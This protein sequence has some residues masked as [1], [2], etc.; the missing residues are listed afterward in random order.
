MKKTVRL[1]VLFITLLLSY[2]VC[3][4]EP[5]NHNHITSEEGI[6]N[7]TSIVVLKNNIPFS[8]QIKQ[9]NSI[10]VIQYD[11]ELDCDVTIPENC[12][13]Q[14]EGGSIKDKGNHKLIG[15]N[16]VIKAGSEI[17]FNTNIALGGCWKVNRFDIRWFGVKSDD[18][19]IDCT[20]II[21][22]VKDCNIPIFFP[23]GTYY[24]S[25][26]YFENK[27][28]GSF[29]IIGEEPFG[30][31]AKVNFMPFDT[32]Q[33]YI[34]KIGGGHE[35]L[36]G[37]GRGYD[38]KIM[39]INFT[40]PQGYAPSILTNSYTNTKGEYLNGGLILDVV[41]IGEFAISGSGIHNMPFLTIGF[42]YE[43][44]FDYIICYGN[45]GKSS[46]PAIQIVN[47]QSQPYSALHVKKLMGEVVVG[48]MIK[49]VG[50]CA[51]SELV[52]DNF[53]FEGTIKWERESVF[54]ESRYSDTIEL[55]DYK[56][57]PIFDLDGCGF[58][59]VNAE[60][61]STNTKW[62]NSLDGNSKQCVRGLLNFNNTV[63]GVNILNLVSN[64]GSEW[65]YITG[66]ASNLYPVDVFIGNT[67]G[68]FQT[69]IRNINLIVEEK[70]IIDDGKAIP[71]KS[72]NL[73]ADGSLND[74][75]VPF[76]IKNRGTSGYI[77]QR[78]N[79]RKC[80]RTLYS[81]Y[82]FNEYGFDLDTNV[83]C[84][85]FEYL[86]DRMSNCDI[87]IEYFDKTRT[88]LTSEKKQ[89][90]A[91]KT[92]RQQVVTI[93]PPVK[94]TMFKIKYGTNNGCDINVYK[95]GIFDSEHVPVKRVG[96]VRPEKS[97]LTPGFHFFDT[98]LGKP[99]YWTGDPV[100]GDK[101]WVDTMGNYPK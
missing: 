12:V 43:C 2:S 100:K 76:F 22:N 80:V 69:D 60:L 63:C 7:S 87:L 74:I 67:N 29:A 34:I 49:T 90:I 39:N 17:I 31:G 79:N 55:S 33:R 36:G 18:N 83:T 23:K 94:A 8:D 99:I 38:I 77:Q 50:R 37:S 97:L 6:H 64:G 93:N 19:T 27:K 70:R 72:N 24:L 10:Y 73:Y 11:F 62:D 58:T 85:Y 1:L 61:N 59:I 32:H 4:S 5:C 47:S 16:T 15:Q 13:L 53:Y 75:T 65:M 44:E 101:G 21:N 54:S 41:E 66:T 91:D 86:I 48:P 92:I 68:K 14:F 84:L 20:K 28:G 88:F 42:I 45:H 40:T 57:I 35:T 3:V 51:G 56:V 82:M 81:S 52:I 30:L 25:E 46:Q 26:L 9:A 71:L 96:S 95:F 89:V 98:S 78:K